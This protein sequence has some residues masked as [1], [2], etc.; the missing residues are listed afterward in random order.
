M[1]R[2]LSGQG[3][4]LVLAFAVVGLLGRPAAE[5]QS[6]NDPV[7]LTFLDL[8]TAPALNALGGT[9]VAE[10]F[11]DPYGF[12]YNPAH[13]G[14]FEGEAALATYPGAVDWLG[15]GLDASSMAA[16]GG[17][18]LRGIGLP[19]SLGLGVARTTLD[20]GTVPVT[21]TASFAP[22]DRY[23][24]VGLGLGLDLPVRVQLGANLRF[25]TSEEAIGVDA[26]GTVLTGEIQGT[27]LD[28]GALVEAPV[29]GLLGVAQQAD[30]RPALD[31]AVGYAQVHVGG[32]VGSG[33]FAQ[34]LPRMARLG[35][36][37]TFGLDHRTRLDAYIQ[38]VEATVAIQ[39]EHQ[40]TRVAADGAVSYEP[41]LGDLNLLD[42]ALLGRGSDITTARR[43]LRLTFFETFG[44]HYGYFDGFGYDAR[45]TSGFE[46]RLGGA[47]R[48][49][50]LST[51]NERLAALAERYDVSFSTATYFAGARSE[52]Q[53]ASLTLRVRF[54]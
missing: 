48:V 27:T 31:L 10:A 35:Y 1:I 29:L 38:L 53:F 28:V 41:V 52:S 40:L 9:G 45:R 37:V 32:E 7:A 4:W 17:V 13:L 25:V 42:N 23:T 3:R 39:A 43:G 54:P 20:F 24:A 18:S 49:Y 36:A 15:L 33:A 44:L 14:G 8:P 16:S 26:D 51:G 21:N 19:V 6:V 47:L 46:V 34:P 2:T 50:A 11:G 30:F 12:L 22:Q 5:A